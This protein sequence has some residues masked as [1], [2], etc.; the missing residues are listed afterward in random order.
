MTFGTTLVLTQVTA[1][2][3][4]QPGRQIH[5]RQSPG[6]SLQIH[7]NRKRFSPKPGTEVESI[8]EVVNIHTKRF[9]IHW[10]HCT[11]L[12][13]LITD[14][15]TVRML[16]GVTTTGTKAKPVLAHSAQNNDD[17][18]EIKIWREVLV[19]LTSTLDGGDH[20]HGEAILTQCILG[21]R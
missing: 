16:L 18:S 11:K 4:T 2:I 15:T 17:V 9:Y 14:R 12:Y 20:F 7:S 21:G 10:Q 3:M 13:G 8:A 5:I 1:G 19:F 6:I